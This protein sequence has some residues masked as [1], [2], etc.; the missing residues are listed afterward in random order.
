MQNF[1]LYYQ[2]FPIHHKRLL[3]ELMLTL[4]NAES[5]LNVFIYLFSKPVARIGNLLFLH[6]MYVWCKKETVYSCSNI[7]Y[8]GYTFACLQCRNTIFFHFCFRQM[9]YTS[10]V[11]FFTILSFHSRN[12]KYSQI[13]EIKIIYHK[14]IKKS[15]RRHI[16]LNI[17]VPRECIIIITKLILLQISCIVGGRQWCFSN[18][19]PSRHSFQHS[20]LFTPPPV[21]ITKRLNIVAISSISLF[22]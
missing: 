8:V 6:I 10:L 4:S 1:I 3:F 11:L 18:L 21:H 15:I 16:R 7:N 14:R 12:E 13:E 17:A 22:L 2:F 9:V 5:S 19:L 20:N